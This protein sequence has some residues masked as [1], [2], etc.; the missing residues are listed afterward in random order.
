MVLGIRG[1]YA[2]S[3]RRSDGGDDVELMLERNFSSR[4]RCTCLR[5]RAMVLG[6]RGRYAGSRRR[7]DDRD[8]GELIPPGSARGRWSGL[9]SFCGESR[10]GCRGREHSCPLSRFRGEAPG[11][12]R[13][14]SA[15]RTGG[16]RSGSFRG[17][18]TVLFIRREKRGESGL[19][20]SPY[21]L[22]VSH[23]ECCTLDRSRLSALI[24]FLRS[25]LRERGRGFLDLNCFPS[26]RNIVV[27]VTVTHHPE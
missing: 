10:A 19:R 14:P 23:T 18:K 12:S 13:L 9:T 8:D 22:P 4:T 5:A 1:R 20:V 7:S 24:E 3:M 16:G 15:A 27:T 25:V 11:A 21:L 2:G 6:T 17:V 26:K